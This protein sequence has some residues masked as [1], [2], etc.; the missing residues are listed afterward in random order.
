MNFRPSAAQIDRMLCSHASN[1]SV[2][3]LPNGETWYARPTPAP[4]IASKMEFHGIYVDAA[5]QA[6]IGSFV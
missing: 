5:W 1:V 4:S 3:V 6:V 2:R